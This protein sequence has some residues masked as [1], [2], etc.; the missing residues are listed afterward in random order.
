VI[1][2]TT[3]VLTAANVQAEALFASFLQPSE[4]P[5]VE[6]VAAAIAGSL[7]SYGGEAG[8]AAVVAAEYGEHPDTAVARMRWALALVLLLPAILD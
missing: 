3:S 8:C 2:V 5:T 4:A 7:R 1:A 6:Q